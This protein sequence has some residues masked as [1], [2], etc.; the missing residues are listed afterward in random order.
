MVMS[1]R[2][3]ST[4]YERPCKFKLKSGK[5]IFGVIWKNNDGLFFS[6]LEGYRSISDMDA[7][8]MDNSFSTLISEDEIIGAEI[9]PAI[10]S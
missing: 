1:T 3:L 10:A 6:S 4:I 9:I 7:S 8:Q 5:E 2:D